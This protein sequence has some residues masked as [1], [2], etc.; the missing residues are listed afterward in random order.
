MD[1]G[2]DDSTRSPRVK[3]AGLWSG[4]AADARTSNTLRQFLPGALEVQDRPPSPAGRWLLW[5][6]LVLFL[7]GITW[8]I[9]GEVDIVVTAPGRIVP[10]GKVKSVQTSEVAVVAAI[11]VRDGQRVQAGEP[12]ISLEDTA[13]EADDLSVSEQLADCS[14]ELAWRTGLESWLAALDGVAAGAS[15]PEPDEQDDAISNSILQ[16][17][18]VE[19]TSRLR[20]LDRDLRA[21]ASERDV[22]VAEHARA[23]AKLEIVKERVLAYS[24]LLA[25][26][27]GARIKHLEMLEQQTDL[28]KTLPV[29]LASQHKLENQS[30]SI[31]ARIV[32]TKSDIRVR[33]LMEI[34]RL[35]AQ[36]A[37]LR[38]DARKSRQRRKRQLL[39]SP[40]TG[41]VQ[42][43]AVHTSGAVTT[44]AQVLMKIVPESAVLEIEALLKNQ[45]RGF[46]RPGQPVAVKV[47]TFNFTKY[48]LIDAEVSGISN[49]AIEEK[50]TVGCLEPA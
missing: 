21:N 25:K 22:V 18:Q 23:S 10:S 28:E 30:E 38:Q 47:D 31:A 8:A 35:V 27:H 2:V 24:S 36:R 6:L 29:L 37:R 50:G 43:L 26:Q 13:A 42:E 17:K 11:H 12:L 41:T 20:G 49:D 48:G 16:Q 9:V 39:Q 15:P 34:D 3:L 7:V 46:V 5:T 19:I 14:R 44:P 1:K 33:N 40:V 32:A 45:D 4:Q